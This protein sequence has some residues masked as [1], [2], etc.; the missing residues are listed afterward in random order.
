MV[1]DRVSTFV[2]AEAGVNHNGDIDMAL[3]LC[4]AAKTS[5]ADAVKFQTFRAED[6]V[7]RDAQTADY[8]RR[9]TGVS[10]QFEM[11]SALSLDEAA[12]ERLAGHCK[13]IGLE[14]MS[15]PFSI[16]AIALLVRVGVKRLKLPSGEL[17]HM[18]LLRVA[19]ST[20]LPLIVSTGMGTIEET[21]QALA[22]IKSEPHSN[23]DVVVL[24]CTSAYP[25]PDTALNLRA[26]HHIRDALG[27]R[28]GYSDHSLGG[29]AAL[30]AV[31]LG[32]NV[33]EKHITLDRSLPGPDHQAS[34]EVREFTQLVSSVRRVEAMLGDGVKMP[35]SD[36]LK[37]ASLVRRGVFAARDFSAGHVLGDDDLVL[38]RPSTALQPVDVGGL[39]GRRLSQPV[40]A[41]QPIER[42]WLS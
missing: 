9:A 28:V 32:A 37:T 23:N 12:H 31:A 13:S 25:A 11:L 3:R 14:F 41:G 24:H 21:A 34:M 6:L 39:L 35:S 26:M 40:R 30:A 29:E 2:I 17:T 5:G 7:T 16:D 27:V 42:E 15:T 8:Q 18:Q 33:I 38:R 1:F 19:A 20:G 4:D 36:E 22:W 10:T